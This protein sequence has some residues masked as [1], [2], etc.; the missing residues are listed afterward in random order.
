MLFQYIRNL[1]A[2]LLTKAENLLVIHCA[3]FDIQKFWFEHFSQMF[4]A[5][6]NLKLFW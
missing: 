4:D 1:S 6:Y 5:K 2:V 3:A